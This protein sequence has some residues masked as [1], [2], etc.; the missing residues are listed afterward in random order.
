MAARRSRQLVIGVVV[1]LALV[2]GAGC[3]PSAYKAPVTK[4]KDSSAVVIESTKKYLTALN[5]TERDSYIYSRAS[6]RAQ[7]QLGKIDEVQVFDPEDIGARIRALDQLADYTDLLYRLANSDAPETIKARA[8]DLGTALTGLSDEIGK[9]SGERNDGFKNASARAFPVIG[10]ILRVIVERKIE[11]A[12]ERAITAG[13]QP[14][15]Q[16]V[17][18]IRTDAA[19]AY[20]RKRAAVS[21]ARRIAVD[22]YNSEFEKGDRA[23]TAKL[24]AYA[25]VVAAAEDRWE[26]FQTARPVE[27]LDAMQQANTAM[28]KFA[29]TPKP[30]V[31]DF[32]T[33]VDAMEL[34]ASTAKRVG[35]AVRALEGR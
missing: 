9:L 24:K 26:A 1:P 29:K 10:E 32:A 4:F 22:S 8:K 17:A 11:E 2:A 13:D 21:N 3:R 14:V 34:F 12:L 18:A 23:D 16:L 20:E 33:F 31:T 7:I 15:N 30:T 25:D 6:Q 5:K 19:V 28:V 27:G 35:D